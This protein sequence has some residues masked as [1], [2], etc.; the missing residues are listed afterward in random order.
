[1]IDDYLEYEKET[2]ALKFI[3]LDNFSVHELNEYEVQLNKEIERVK[4]EIDKKSKTQD[5][6]EKYFK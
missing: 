4:K 5:S 3:N 1:M 6:A 2:K